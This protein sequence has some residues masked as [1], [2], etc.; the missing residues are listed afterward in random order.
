MSVELGEPIAERTYTIIGSDETVR[1]ALGKPRLWTDLRDYCLPYSIS[2]MGGNKT[3]HIVGID[4]FHALELAF[5]ALRAELEAF[6]INH[7]VKLFWEGDD[8]G[9]LGF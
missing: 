8:S 1:V 4:Q 6:Q 9:G 2:G 3:M 5:K 7:G